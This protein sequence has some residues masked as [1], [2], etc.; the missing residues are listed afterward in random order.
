MKNQFNTI[1]GKKCG[2]TKSINQ[3]RYRLQAENLFLD[4]IKKEIKN[5]TEYSHGYNNYAD[6][7]ICD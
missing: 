5:A 4:I 6:G 7:S 1:K 3:V 2:F